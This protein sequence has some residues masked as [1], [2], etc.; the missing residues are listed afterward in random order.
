MRSAATQPT[1]AN[2]MQP[3]ARKPTIGCTLRQVEVEHFEQ[4]D[5][6]RIG[7]AFCVRLQISPRSAEGGNIDDANI[8]DAAYTME[9][10]ITMLRWLSGNRRR[11]ENKQRA[12][13][14]ALPDGDHESIP[15]Q[16]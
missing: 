6:P 5:I 3:G 15:K 10:R 7:K 4:N 16:V 8:I 13:P 2:R 12:G 1:S 11:G 14:A 9:V